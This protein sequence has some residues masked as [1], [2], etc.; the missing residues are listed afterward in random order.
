M[1]TEDFKIKIVDLGYGIPLSGRD[2]SWYLKSMGKGTPTYYA[3]EILKRQPYQGTD[4]DIFS[5]GVISLN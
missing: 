5:F 3:P 1:L 4:C 2:G